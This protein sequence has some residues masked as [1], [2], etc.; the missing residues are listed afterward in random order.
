MWGA[1]GESPLLVNIVFHA[2]GG[3]QN[4]L[5]C[6]HMWVV[7]LSGW[8]SH[9]GTKRETCWSP[10]EMYTNC[11]SYRIL[12]GSQCT[13]SNVCTNQQKR[14]SICQST[15]LQFYFCYYCVKHF[16]IILCMS[17][18]VFYDVFLWWVEH[19]ERETEWAT[20]SSIVWLTKTT[21]VL[22][23]GYSIQVMH[24]CS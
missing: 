23:P 12:F 21:L 22:L 1:R 10:M 8:Q 11:D 6:V 16:Y 15:P 14:S 18:D 24:V 20:E 4:F 7:A 13:H 19:R 17:V 9:H 5:Q 3:V 2:H